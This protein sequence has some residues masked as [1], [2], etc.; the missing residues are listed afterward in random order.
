M[1][2]LISNFRE[3]STGRDDKNYK[4]MIKYTHRNDG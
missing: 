3:D 1:F 2:K 4:K